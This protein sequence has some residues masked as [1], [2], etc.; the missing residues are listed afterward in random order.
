MKGT[1]FRI[2]LGI[3]VALFLMSLLMLATPDGMLLVHLALALIATVP[4][5]VAATSSQRGWAWL[6]VV[7][8]IALAFNDWRLA[9]EQN[10]RM[11]RTW[12][13]VAAEAKQASSGPATQPRP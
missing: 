6:A 10:Q 8:A 13:H 2:F 4:L 12:Q 11:V 7:A 9:I 3:Y 5:A 1:V